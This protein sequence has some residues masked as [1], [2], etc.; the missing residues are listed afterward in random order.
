MAVNLY[1]IVAGYF[2]VDGGAMFGVVPRVLWEQKYEP[3]DKNR[4]SQALRVLLIIDGDRNI[5]VDVGAGNWHD[6]KFISN[7]GLENDD[8]SFDTALADHNLSTDDITDVVLTHLHFDHA[9]GWITQNGTKL[10][11][12]FARARTWV[13]KAQL[14]WAK[15]SSP[16]DKASYM[17]AYLKPL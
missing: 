1:P 8:F 2:R 14:D 6:A 4:I 13:Q 12:T 9:G 15:E 10:V 11:P 3:D 5:L 16:I 17:D 7:Y